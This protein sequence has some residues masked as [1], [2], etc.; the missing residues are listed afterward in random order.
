[1]LTIDPTNNRHIYK[2]DDGYSFTYDPDSKLWTDG[3]MSNDTSWIIGDIETRMIENT[4][5]F[6]D[7]FGVDST[8]SAEEIRGARAAFLADQEAMNSTIKLI[9]IFTN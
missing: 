9:E 8:L 7:C 4:F 1:M 2:T 3:D 6:D 5:Q